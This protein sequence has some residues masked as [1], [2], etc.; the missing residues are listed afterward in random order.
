MVGAR[1]DP[2]SLDQ[3]DRTASLNRAEQFDLREVQ[4]DV[5]EAYE[6]GRKDERASRRRHPVMMT[7]TFAAAACGVALL[8]LAAI[9]GSFAGGGSVADQNLNAA[10]NRAEPQVR[11]AASQ[12]GQSL[13][14]AGVKAK[15]KANGVPG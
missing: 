8:A 11:D 6:R 12:A 15:A 5:R 13:R 2:A 4:A 9:N 1:L 10:V 14:D 7:L 3:A